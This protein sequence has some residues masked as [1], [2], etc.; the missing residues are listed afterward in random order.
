MPFIAGE[1]VYWRY[2]EMNKI[3]RTISEHIPNSD[4]VSA[5]GC[6]ML[7]D[8]SDPHFGREGQLL[9]GER[10]ADK[11]LSIVYNIK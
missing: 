4:Y 11:V 8:E 1:L 5:E 3:I 2:T 10:Y 9:L 6:D 7:K